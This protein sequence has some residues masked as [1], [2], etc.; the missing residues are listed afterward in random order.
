M[1]TQKYK[2]WVYNAVF[3]LYT[4]QILTRKFWLYQA[5]FRL[6][7]TYSLQN[8][9]CIMQYFDC[10]KP[11]YSL[12]GFDFIEGI[13][14]FVKRVYSLQGFDCVKQ[15]CGCIKPEYSL[16]GSDF[17]KQIVDFLKP[18]CIHSKDISRFQ[19]WNVK[20]EISSRKFF[21]ETPKFMVLR[22][23]RKSRNESPSR[24]T[25]SPHLVLRGFCNLRLISF[26]ALTPH[27]FSVRDSL[28]EKNMSK[29]QKDGACYQG[30]FCVRTKTNWNL[31]Q[32]KNKRG[33]YWGG[34][35][36]IDL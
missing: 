18:E 35:I 20:S 14:D 31:N 28:C 13:L 3:W 1:L 2:C 5:D 8:F 7:T 33:C 17:L 10:I 34:Q 27:F 36:H 19:K 29:I 25:R 16:T 32:Q 30:W 12:K 11:Q 23:F 21:I 6:H 4:A 24:G 26:A 15:C 22:G 9:V